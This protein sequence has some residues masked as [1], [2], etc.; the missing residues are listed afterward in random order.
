MDLS[1]FFCDFEPTPAENAAFGAAFA[2]VDS[3]PLIQLMKEM[4]PNKPP[5]QI[6]SGYF[7]LLEDDHFINASNVPEPPDS[8]QHEHST[9]HA[10]NLVDE[11]C[12]SSGTPPPP[13]PPAEVVEVAK[14]APATIEDRKGKVKRVASKKRAKPGPAQGSRRGKSWTHEEHKSGY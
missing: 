2:E 6:K 3:P 11:G 8:F 10:E 9:G 4:I 14:E 12:A 5:L 7:P 1:T 13:P